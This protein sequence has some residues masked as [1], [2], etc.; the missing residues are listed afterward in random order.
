MKLK[1]CQQLT[2][3]RRWW[4]ILEPLLLSIYV[5]A[6]SRTMYSTTKVSGHLEFDRLVQDLI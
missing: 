1:M 2:M 4:D 5:G 3:L 6:R